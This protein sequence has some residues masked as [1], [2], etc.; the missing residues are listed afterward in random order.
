M[1]LLAGCG[2]HKATLP[3][4]APAYP[5]ATDAKTAK[6]AS[7][8]STDWTLPA[9][10]HDTTVYDWYVA[11]LTKLGWKVTQRNETG[12][13][14]EKGRNTLDVGVRGTTLEVNKG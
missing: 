7:Y 13:H 1:L 4:V 5:G 9:G 2:G 14:A 10:T 11:K 8:T 3:P 12:V 6:A